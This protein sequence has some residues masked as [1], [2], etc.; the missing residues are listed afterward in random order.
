[1]STFSTWK[2]STELGG[3]SKMSKIMSTWFLNDPKADVSSFGCNCTYLTQSNNSRIGGM[4]SMFPCK[5][6]TRKPLIDK[7]QTLQ[8]KGQ[9]WITFL[10]WKWESVPAEVRHPHHP[11]PPAEHW[12]CKME[13]LLS[14]LTPKISG[15]NLNFFFT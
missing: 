9:C 15:K 8:G 3:W 12:N 6:I 13:Y 10:T 7:Y 5:K 4:N 11:F 14:R 1:M 2:V